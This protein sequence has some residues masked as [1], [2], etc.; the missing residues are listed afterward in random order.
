MIIIEEEGI[1]PDLVNLIG[2]Q[3][4]PLEDNIGFK[5]T[6]AESAD[7]I[8]GKIKE[9]QICESGQPGKKFM[10]GRQGTR[11]T[12]QLVVSQM[13]R[14]QVGAEVPQNVP[15]ALIRQGLPGQEEAFGVNED[16]RVNANANGR[17]DVDEDPGEIPIVN[18][19]Q[20]IEVDI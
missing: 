4:K 18:N 6:A 10:R 16:F 13:D 9:L 12:G 11:T 7:S 14:G 15:E 20:S 2:I 5:L 3:N 8:V 19:F 17:V 1:V